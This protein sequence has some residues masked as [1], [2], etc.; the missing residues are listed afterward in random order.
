MSN[1]SARQKELEALK[2]FRQFSRQLR[3]DDKDEIGYEAANSIRCDMVHIADA[4]RSFVRAA[5]QFWNENGTEENDWIP[6]P[7]DQITGRERALVETGWYFYQRARAARSTRHKWNSVIGPQASFP[8]LE[9]G[10]S[11][12]SPT[13]SETGYASIALRIAGQL[14][15][16][17]KDD[18]YAGVLDWKRAE[19]LAT[20][21]RLE[22]IQKQGSREKHDAMRKSHWSL[23][24]TIVYAATGNPDDAMAHDNAYRAECEQWIWH[25]SIGR[26][27]LETL[28]PITMKRLSRGLLVAFDENW[29]DDSSVKSAQERLWNE[30]ASNSIIANAID[31]H[32]TPRAIPAIEWLRLVATDEGKGVALTYGEGGP[33][34]YRDP[35]FP[36]EKIIELFGKSSIAAVVEQVTKGKSRFSDTELLSF[37]DAYCQKQHKV[38]GRW[39]G[40]KAARKW[41]KNLTLPVLQEQIDEIH[42]LHAAKRS[43]YSRSGGRPIAID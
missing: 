9:V 4:A 13:L 20:V 38:T 1:N 33:I 10:Q 26:Y 34:A 27:Q 25:D 21:Y 24:M 12:I 40:R 39:P 22:R 43:G 37:Y 32:G 19:R 16:R 36:R 18:V 28:S 14:R 2:Q 42:N 17:L 41:A 6:E 23:P 35:L 15:Q 31:A 5:A 8:K 30:L 7:S 29:I 3:F 11:A